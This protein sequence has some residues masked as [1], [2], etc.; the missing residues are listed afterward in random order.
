MRIG[1]A[2]GKP[3]GGLGATDLLEYSLALVALGH[4]VVV[5]C[6]SSAVDSARLPAGLS[7]LAAGMAISGKKNPIPSTVQACR[8]AGLLRTAGGDLDVLHEPAFPEF[9]FR[10]APLVRVP[11]VLDVRTLPVSSAVAQRLGA[12]ILRVQRRLYTRT[13]VIDRALSLTIFGGSYPEFP[14]P[15]NTDRFRPG[16]NEQL[17]NQLGVGPQDL[18]GVYVGSMAPVRGL[19]VLLQAIRTATREGADFRFLLVG[20][21]RADLQALAVEVDRLGLG[22][23]VRLEG[24]VD[25]DKVP[26]YL[27]AADFAVAY[28]PRRPQFESQPPIKTLEYL[29]AGLPTVATNTSGNLRFIHDG[30][31]GLVSEDRPQALGE[32]LARVVKD[33]ELRARLSSNARA[34]VMEWDAK[35]VAADRL[36]PVYRE[37]IASFRKTAPQ[38]SSGAARQRGP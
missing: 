8:L 27:Q 21:G 26:G 17:R 37:A 1:L 33:P 32:A 14:L 9:G 24:Y 23:R 18:L 4:E 25:Y 15:I 12:A 16:R 19:P 2:V 6:P 28:V 35:R 10:L 22:D 34:S 38:P 5:A 31:N 7:I 29:A 30:V 13:A 11:S 36:V 3:F 20:G